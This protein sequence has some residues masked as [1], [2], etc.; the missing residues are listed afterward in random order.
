M[1][2][3]LI[4]KLLILIAFSIIWISYL[5]VDFYS[6]TRDI[7]EIN[8]FESDLERESKRYVMCPGD[9]IISSI[10]DLV[11]GGFMPL[12]SAFMTLLICVRLD[13]RKTNGS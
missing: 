13:R 10:E 12:I 9:G 8:V 1:N 5:F 2:T 6:A 3:T 4:V 11:F 7:D